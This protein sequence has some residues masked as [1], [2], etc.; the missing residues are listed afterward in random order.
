MHIA[1]I[2]VVWHMTGKH[3]I[4]LRACLRGVTDGAML[5]YVCS[6]FCM[7]WLNSTLPVLKSD[8]Q[9]WSQTVCNM[10]Y[11]C[12]VHP[13]IRA[14][15]VIVEFLTDA[16]RVDHLIEEIVKDPIRADFCIEKVLKDDYHWGKSRK[17][18]D[19]PTSCDTLQ[20]DLNKVCCQNVQK[21]ARKQEMLK[22]LRWKTYLKFR[23]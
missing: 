16:I 2:N 13:A 14:D 11:A 1:C 19:I 22:R 8:S 7:V 20:A 3:A 4:L 18:V 5:L 9:S 21:L 23:G 15:C 12:T 17:P 10:R 6:T